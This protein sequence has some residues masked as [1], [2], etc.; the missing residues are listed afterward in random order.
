MA[1]YVTDTHPLLWYGEARHAKLSRGAL[2][3]FREAEAG[4]ALIC[5]P[6]VVLWEVSLLILVGRIRLSQPFSEWVDMLL[7]QPGFELAP[8]DLAVIAETL[9]FH[10]NNDLFDA[11]V[12]ATA[13]LKDVPLITKDEDMVLSGLIDVAW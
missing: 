1:L 11:A 3:I 7:A 9:Q 12:V 8:L 2:R 6:A 5:V 13:H 10:L 4:R